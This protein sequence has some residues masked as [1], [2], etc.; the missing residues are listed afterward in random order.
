M[1]R[2]SSL[3][4]WHILVLAIPLTLGGCGPH[5]TALYSSRDIERAPADTERIIIGFLPINDYPSLSK[6]KTL[7]DIDFFTLDG[8]GATDAKLEALSRVKFDRL[9]QV[10]L[11]NCPAVSD[12]GIQHLSN[13]K[14]IR[15]M[16]LEGTS[17]TDKG[18]EIM[19]SEMSL[20]G[21]NVANCSNVT[22]RGISVL[23]ESKSLTNSFSFSLD[24]VNQEQA[25][26][27]LPRMK[28]VRYPAIV[29]PEGKLDGNELEMLAQEHG[30]PL[31]IKKKGALQTLLGGGKP[32]PVRR[33]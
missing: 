7:K 33:E 12:V 23:I 17:I 4:P 19:A 16:Q 10:S 25:R 14:S 22:I 20:T 31:D 8:S 27:L 1:R 2:R 5:P 24:A 21:V 9:E 13:I 28:K 6:F 3:V 18:L 11:L 32:V 30:I 29:D 26:A 15:G